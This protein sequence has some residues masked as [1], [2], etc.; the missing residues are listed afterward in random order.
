MLVLEIL[1]PVIT[2]GSRADSYSSDNYWFESYLF[3]TPCFTLHSFTRTAW[4]G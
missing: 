2:I 4:F 1:I 3:P